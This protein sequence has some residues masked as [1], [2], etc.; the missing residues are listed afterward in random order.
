MSMRFYYAP[1]SCA[2]A[3]HI[4]LEHIGADYEAEKLNL[5]DNDQN[6][7]DYLAINPKG[8]V[9]ALV[10]DQGILT[11]TPALL[12]YLAQTFPAAK[13][14]PLDDAFALAQM[15]SI[16]SWF[17]ST[18]HVHHAHGAR[19][20]RWSDDLDAQKSMKAKVAENMTGAAELIEKEILRGPWVM[21]DQ[22]T[23]AD[24]Y[25]FTMTS[26]MASD[27]V[28]MKKFPKLADHFKRMLALPAV[29]KIA[30]LHGISAQ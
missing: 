17:C 5:R 14:A 25:L 23:V 7:P 8:R 2:L 15:Q 26:W 4:V 13:L 29:K 30:P 22:F 11:E 20:R 12:L 18:V 1:L 3:T 21:G 27:G 28:D 24:A 9:P 16:N 6:T 19:G 10:T